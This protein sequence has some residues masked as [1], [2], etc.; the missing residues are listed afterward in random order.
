[1][2]KSLV[3]CIDLGTT[4]IKAA[5]CGP[6]GNVESKVQAPADPG[7]EFDAAHTRAASLE[8][9]GRLMAGSRVPPES[10][11]AVSITSQR[12]T[13]V[14]LAR[15]GEPSGPAVSW[16]DTRC[17][18]EVESFFLRF[19]AAHFQALTGLPPSALWSLSK[20]L[21]IRERMPE[22]FEATARFCLLPDFVYTALGCQRLV[23]DLASASLTGMLDT[24]LLSWSPDILRA[25]GLSRDMLPGL[26]P[27]GTVIGA[28]SGSAAAATG[29]QAGTLLVA[30]G[31]DQQCAALGMGVVDP[32]DAGLCLGTAAVVSC[33]TA[34]PPGETLHGKA[35]S[36]VH[37]APERWVLEGIH[38][39]FGS[40]LSWAAAALAFGS[41]E[42]LEHAAASASSSGCLFVPHLAGCGSPDFNPL[43]PG[44]FSGLT[45]STTREAMARGVLE[46]VALETR[47]I[48]DALDV[49]T[50][51]TRLRVTGGASRSDLLPRILADM[52]GRELLLCAEP[53]ATLVGAA[54]L[55]WTGAGHYADSAAA[56]RA[57]AAGLCAA[58][59]GPGPERDSA[60]VLFR[61]YRH[62]VNS[63]LDQTRSVG[64][65]P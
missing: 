49:G 27:S 10:V 35:F 55:A 8:L 64:G 23:T 63:L 42:E 59:V 30:G 24:R 15:S 40:A 18:P 56:A 6:G 31:G 51:V 1:M 5:L 32:G 14:P 39:T 13:I 60:N 11:A 48:L 47:R 61:Q 28:V 25:A 20:I 16:Q 26:V 43:A 12:A 38:N 34:S 41:V 45:L 17:A 22:R 58:S 62:L 33:P 3:C 65:S 37:A 7:A 54:L 44:A 53:E 36:T 21:W 57:R 29:L 50:A 9:I 4:G 19:P 2:S 46:G 52:T